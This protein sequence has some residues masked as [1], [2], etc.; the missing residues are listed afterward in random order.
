MQITKSEIQI[1][2]PV[3]FLSMKFS[4]KDGQINEKLKKPRLR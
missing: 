3:R 1:E 4:K 2:N